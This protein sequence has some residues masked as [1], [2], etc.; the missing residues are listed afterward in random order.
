MLKFQIV[1]AA[2]AVYVVLVTV[3]MRRALVTSDPTARNAAAKQLLLVVTLGVPIA[4]VA[5]FYLM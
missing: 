4:L 5:I 3:M 2:F 1:G